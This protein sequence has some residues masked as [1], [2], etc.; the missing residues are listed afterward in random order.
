M[1]DLFKQAYLQHTGNEKEA[2]EQLLKLKKVAN[3]KMLAELKETML[4][5]P[6][7]DF[8]LEDLDG[9]FI[10][11]ADLKGKIVIIDF[12]AT[13][14]APCKASFPGMKQAVEKYRDDESVRFLFINS[15]ERV[16]DWKKNAADFMTKNNYPFHV[17]LDT[18]NRAATAF[19]VAVIPTKFVI[20]KK[21]KIRFKSEGFSGSTDQLVE[22]LSLMIEMLR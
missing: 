14:C 16:E 20:D 10:S 9:Q 6:A 19:D 17:L 12:W 18:E 22:E 1:E 15:S 11:L 5:S 3:E 4:D 7:P 13:W 2:S 8:I 21:G